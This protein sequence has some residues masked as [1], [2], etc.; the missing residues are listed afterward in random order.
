MTGEPAFF[1]ASKTAFTLSVP[2]Q[3]TA[4]NANPSDLQIE[5]NVFRSSPYT[6][7]G[8]ILSK[9]LIPISYIFFSIC[10]FCYLVF[11]FS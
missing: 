7:P 5:N 10:F 3:L 1:A 9:T 8:L 2:T 4:G 6:T 11:V